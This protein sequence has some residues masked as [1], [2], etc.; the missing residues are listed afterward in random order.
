MTLNQIYN[1]LK[2]AGLYFA[3]GAMACEMGEP[4]L[5][6]CHIGMRS[7][8]DYAKAQFSAGWNAAANRH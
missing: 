5:Y 4:N 6:G 1:E 8:L 3:A 7:T 2:N